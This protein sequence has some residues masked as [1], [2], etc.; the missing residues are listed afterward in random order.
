M[1]CTA[2]IKKALEYI[3][4]FT[5]DTIELVLFFAADLGAIDF[6]QEPYPRSLS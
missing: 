1:A 2:P 5:E 3:T 4:A 6:V